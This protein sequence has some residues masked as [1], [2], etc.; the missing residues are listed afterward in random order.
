VLCAAIASRV[1][2]SLVHLD[3]GVQWVS[4]VPGTGIWNDFTE[5][6]L[7]QVKYLSQGYMLYR[8]ID[9]QYPPLF[10]YSILPFYDLGGASAAWIPI[11]LA[12]ALTA[13][14]VYLIARRFSTEKVAL[15]AG[16]AYAFSPVALVNEG[17]IWLSS[18][19]MTLFLLISLFLLRGG[20]PLL[21]GGALAIAVLF[22]QEAI[23]VLPVYLVFIAKSRASLFKSGGFF[24]FTLFGGLS[25]FLLQAPKAVLIHL[26]IWLPFNIG[27]SEPGRLP[28]FTPS[29]MVSIGQPCEYTVV[30]H[31]YSGT[32][33]GEIANFKAYAWFLQIS[34]LDAMAA[35]IAPILFVLFGA[36]LIAVRRS[37]RILEM[38]SAYSIIGGL[39]IFSA[40][41]HTSFAYYFVPVYAL[42]LASV[43]TRRSLIVGLAATTLGF[44]AGEGPVQFIIP[45]ACIFAFTLIQDGSLRSSATSPG[46]PDTN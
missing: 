6:Y 5:I 12:D 33:C 16:L 15:V 2:V 25:P 41:V 36:G 9:T 13:P 26:A 35:F 38:A 45:I 42:I 46:N 11:A 37:P 17:Y 14:L 20:R 28:V 32:I 40:L 4:G 43:T 34:R 44:F 7:H 21:S 39:F 24:A 29:S 1:I 27:P 8:D 3:I 22:N 31:V 30:P 23:F 19:P 18:Q 10:L